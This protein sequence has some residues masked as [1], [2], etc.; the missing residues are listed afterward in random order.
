M[1]IT[2][3]TSWDPSEPHQSSR[4]HSH[5]HQ[6]HSTWLLC[7]M[8]SPSCPTSNSC[9]VFVTG[10]STALLWPCHAVVAT[11]RLSCCCCPSAWRSWL[12]ST[13]LDLTVSCVVS[14]K[15]YA[16]LALSFPLE[17]TT[18]QLYSRYTMIAPTVTDYSSPWL[19]F[20][21][22]GLVMI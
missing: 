4:D 21:S 8:V 20:C 2:I 9:L 1:I 15:L 18:T 12:A 6:L 10:L 7:F 22:S 14:T 19:L 16:P 11:Q 17:N 13:D 5:H 3:I